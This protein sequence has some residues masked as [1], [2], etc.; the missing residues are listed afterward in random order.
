MITY[1]NTE[2]K[3]TA[4][5]LCGLSQPDFQRHKEAGEREESRVD[6]ENITGFV[7]LLFPCCSSSCL[8]PAVHLIQPCTSVFSDD[9]ELNVSGVLSPGNTLKRQ[10]IC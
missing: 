6:R 9:A 2:F 1:R 5:K 4:P 8:K 3:P 10:S 7:T